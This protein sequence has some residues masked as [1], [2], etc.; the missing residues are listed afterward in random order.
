MTNYN[1]QNLSAYP[2][3]VN[4]LII[5]PYSVDYVNLDDPDNL[6]SI[7]AHGNALR[8][9]DRDLLDSIVGT[10]YLSYLIGAQDGDDITVDIQVREVVE[11]SDQNSLGGRVITW[12]VSSSAEDFLPVTLD[13]ISHDIG[14]SVYGADDV[15]GSLTAG[16]GFL[17]LTLTSSDPQTVYLVGTIGDRIHQ[18]SAAITWV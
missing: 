2:K 10:T 4:G 18:S 7:R 9:L 11:G 8:V 6:A 3:D 5:D 15:N 1:I 12:F 16:T 13:S 17:R 14:S